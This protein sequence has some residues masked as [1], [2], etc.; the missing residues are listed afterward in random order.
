MKKNLTIKL[1]A[2]FLVFF[3][4]QL[5]AQNIT[6]KSVKA[7]VDGTS[8]MHD[9]AM[10]ASSGTFSG[11]VSGNA[12]TNV[13]LE[14]PVKNLKSEKGKMMDNKAYSALKADTHSKISFTAS[15]MNIGKGNVSGKLTIAGVTKTV[16]IPVSVT[17]S[18]SSY[19]I[20]GTADLLL[21]DYGM[22]RPGFMGVKT[23]DGV[24]VTVTVNA[25]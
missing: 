17:K 13:K 12:I 16:S 22:K 20:T 10:T 18:G 24:K 14:I 1:F 15:S 11:T 4:G 23:G 25:G 5:F 19:N 8:P 7:V 2:L 21:S 3:S 6:G 9:W